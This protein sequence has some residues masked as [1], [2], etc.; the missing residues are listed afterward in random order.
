[1]LGLN[2]IRFVIPGED[3]PT[4]H[5]IRP[6]GNVPGYWQC[7]TCYFNWSAD[8]HQRWALFASLERGAN[9]FEANSASPPYWM[10]K[11]LWMS[12]YGLPT[13]SNMFASITLSEQILNDMRI[14]KDP[15]GSNG[16]GLIGVSY[17]NSSVPPKIYLDFYA[18]KQY[19]KFIRP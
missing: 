14:L 10:T 18:F 4:H 13:T 11:R 1:G 16:W 17:T 12:E 19:T 15:N 5:H 2:V 6:E 8:E 9:I 3:N 7:P